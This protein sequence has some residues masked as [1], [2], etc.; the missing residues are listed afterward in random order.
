MHIPLQPLVLV[1]LAFVAKQLLADFFLQSGWM[2]FGKKAEAGWLAPLLVHA[3]IHALGTFLIALAIAP[4]LWWLGLVD[5][6]VHA[7][8][9][10]AKAVWS[11]G[12]DVSN[13][14]FWWAFGSDQAAHQLTHFVFVLA[15]VPKV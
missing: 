14:A 1:Y 6:V 4:A 13:G 5:L 3:A 10:R 2:V 15:L 8:I 11:R 9:D 12:L 7:A